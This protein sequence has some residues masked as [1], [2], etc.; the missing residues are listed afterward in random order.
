MCLLTTWNTEINIFQHLYCLKYYWAHDR[1]FLS[2]SSQKWK[3]AEG[4]K[5]QKTPGCR[6]SSFEHQITS[7]LLRLFLC[8]FPFAPSLESYHRIYVL[9]LLT[10]SISCIFFRVK[11]VTSFNDTFPT[12]TKLLAPYIRQ[13]LEWHERKKCVHGR[14][15]GTT[16]FKMLVFIAL[17]SWTFACGY[18]NVCYMCFLYD[19]Q[20]VCLKLGG[21]MNFSS[22]FLRIKFL[23]FFNTVRVNN[24]W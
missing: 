9:S 17:V 7:D 1:H 6:F 22:F 8:S 19:D 16:H 23:I 18:T 11:Y 5:R 20:L 21:A 15:S 4:K 2:S 24:L 10:M 12:Y 14:E 3:R 13:Y